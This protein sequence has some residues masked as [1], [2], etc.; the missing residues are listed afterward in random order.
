MTSLKKIYM[1]DDAY[2]MMMS[3]LNASISSKREHPPARATP[4]VLQRIP[5]RLAGICTNLNSPGGRAF[6]QK[7]VPYLNCIDQPI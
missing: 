5:T 7:S 3:G 4:R 6:A 2:K 1:R